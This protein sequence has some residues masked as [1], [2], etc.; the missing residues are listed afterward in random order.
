MDDVKKSIVLSII[1]FFSFCS[2]AYGE[3]NTQNFSSANEQFIQNNNAEDVLNKE[4]SSLVEQLGVPETKELITA[5]QEGLNIEMPLNEQDMKALIHHQA[6]QLGIQLGDTQ[7]NDL[8]EL[9]MQ[10]KDMN[11]NWDA[12]NNHI[13]EMTEQ[14][15]TFVSTE[16]GQSFFNEVLQGVKTIVNAVLS[17]FQ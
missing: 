11:I 13:Q 14:V 8:S 10:V 9:F 1:L 16:K 4:I 12:I 2:I 15:Q 7:L 3:N 17:L 5:I 6:E